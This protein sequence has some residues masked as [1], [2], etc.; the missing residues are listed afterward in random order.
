LI[1]AIPPLTTP[2]MEGDFYPSLTNPAVA[3]CVEVWQ[4]V[5]RATW[6]Q[7]CNPYAAERC[8]GKAYRLALPPLTGYQ[9]IRDFIACASY[10]ILLGAIKPGIGTKLA[11]T[12]QV[13][14]L[15]LS[16]QSKTLTP[17]E[18]RNDVSTWDDPQ[19]PPTISATQ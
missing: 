19:P 10:G 1:K 15:A 5:H 3:L 4:K 6:E 12:A 17:T 2:R 14:L 11:Y 18:P 13:A 7:T 8:A 16:Q 9:N